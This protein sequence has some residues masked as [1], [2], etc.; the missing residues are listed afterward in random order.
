[1][2]AALLLELLELLLELL[3]LLL[4]LLLRVLLLLLWVLVL[5]LLA[6]A[7]LLQLLLP[8]QEQ[9]EAAPAW[10]SPEVDPLGSAQGE[11]SESSLAGFLREQD[12]ILW[13]LQECRVFFLVRIVGGC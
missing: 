13:W 10:Q 3:E 1:V 7:L 6:V 12:A 8:D 9:A 4:L 5:L 2:A 11:N